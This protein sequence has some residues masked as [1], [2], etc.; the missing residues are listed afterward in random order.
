[1]SRQELS[2]YEA[3]LKD[4]LFDVLRDITTAQKKLDEIHYA[5]GIL[6]DKV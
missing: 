6:N 2:A 3:H 4:Y 5:K 1:M